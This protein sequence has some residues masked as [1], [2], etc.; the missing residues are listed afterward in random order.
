[1]LGLDLLLVFHQVRGRLNRFWLGLYHFS[2]LL[3]RFLMPDC[4]NLRKTMHTEVL[5]SSSVL[6]MLFGSNQV[7]SIKSRGEGI[8]TDDFGY[9]FTQ[10]SQWSCLV[11]SLARSQFGIPDRGHERFLDQHQVLS[12][13]S[14]LRLLERHTREL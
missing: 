12:N 5:L 11:R 9:F 14:Y 13:S 4:Q 2:R 8:V 10:C 1:M 7:E 3:F 6:T